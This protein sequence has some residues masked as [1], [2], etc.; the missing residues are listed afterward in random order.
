MKIGAIVAGAAQ[1]WLTLTRGNDGATRAAFE[2][3]L[4]PRNALASLA[5]DC[6]AL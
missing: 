4:A 1:R 6:V 5:P 3:T 2:L